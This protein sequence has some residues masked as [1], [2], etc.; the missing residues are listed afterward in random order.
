M[1]TYV[2]GASELGKTRSVMDEFGYSNVYAVHNYRANPFD[3]YRG[4]HVLLLDEYSS[5][6]RIQ[7][8]NVYLD[9]YPLSLPARY[10]NKQACYERVFIVSNL[11]LREQYKREQEEAPAV[12]AAFLRRI[13]KVVHFLEDGT[14]REYSTREY[15]GLRDSE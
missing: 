13:H 5:S 3:G 7:D 11:D 8:M 1:T 4:Q 15:M 9:G 10:S 14:R 2:F 6:F 12:W